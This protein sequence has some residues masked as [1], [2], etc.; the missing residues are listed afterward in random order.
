MP[1]PRVCII[2]LNYNRC[3]DT[4]ECLNSL[5]QCVYDSYHILVVDN[6][7][8][9]QSAEKLRR[10]F[11]NLEIISTGRNLGYTGGINFGIRH[12]LQSPFE[13]ILIL[14]NDTLVTP[15]F[16]NHLAAAMEEHP[17]AAA[18]GG[19][20]YCEHER[21]QIWYA[22][23]RL[24]QWRGMAMHEQKGLFLEPA[25]LNGVRKVT[26]ITGCLILLRVSLLD[27]IGLEDERFFMYLD[28]IEFSAR[29]RAK[30][31]DLLYVPHSIIYH[32]VIDK[33]NENYFKRAYPAAI[34]QQHAFKLYYSV[35]N[36]FLLIKTALR[37][38]QK[39]AAGVYFLS[40]ISIKLLIWRL[41][42]PRF[43]KA[44]WFGLQDFWAA[45]FYEGRGL[46]EFAK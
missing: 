38:P 24:L 39:L 2:L 40:I 44:A 10:E 45:R 9:D 7:S 43:F 41:I 1:N 22:G 3:Q 35:R 31:R 26:F 11:S 15:D 36:R 28:D 19:T 46:S 16:L 14:N 6:A 17:N 37:G 13:Y 32:K 30:G 27:K 29:I 4:I 42:N 12:A 18:A 5:K 21:K 25:V 33:E 8:T 34:E 23:G 20:I